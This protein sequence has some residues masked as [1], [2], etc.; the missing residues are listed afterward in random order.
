MPDKYIG[1][2]HR[3]TIKG[4]KSIK[5]IDLELKPVNILIGANGAG[6]SNF[7]KFFEIIQKIVDKN[8]QLYAA[9]LGGANKIFY[10]GRKV[11]QE[12]Y[13]KL[14][15]PPNAYE[16]LLAA[17]ETDN[18]FFK[19]EIVQFFTDDINY[20]GEVKTED[21]KNDG[22]RESK[23][24]SPLGGSKGWFI[25]NYIKGWQV[26]HFHDTSA[27]SPLKQATNINNYFSLTKDGGNLPAFLRY[28]RDYH[29]NNYIEIVKTVQRVAPFFYD[30]ILEPEL[31]NKEMIRLKW[32]H[33]GNPDY[34][35]VSDLSDGT[36]R[37][38]CIA[39]LLLQPQLP[40]VIIID[41][42]ELGLH[43]FALQ[44]VAGLFAS[45]SKES[46]VI[47]STQSPV[48]A[49]Y[50]NAEDVIAVDFKDNASIFKR[51]DKKELESWLEDFGVGEL[52]QKNL[53]GGMPNYE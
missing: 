24:L 11:T 42:P 19:K 16:A 43:P 39:T 35:D 32:K 51:L 17:D 4:Y 31:N 30:F 7:I 15:F 28:I 27:S 53:V 33:I 6:K 36:L 48:F 41:E 44:L 52:W 5:S 26:Y 18:F 40:S 22:G 14:Y 25:H 37:F 9:Q 45:V 47:A 29:E 34:F 1:K 3:I 20:S 13:F 21:L 23:L 8:L 50:F 49:D 10:F 46:Q 2:V 38:I 12:L